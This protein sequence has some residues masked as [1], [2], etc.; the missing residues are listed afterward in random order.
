MARE[1]VNMSEDNPTII[2]RP[3]WLVIDQ[4]TASGGIRYERRAL[5]E[6]TINRGN[7]IKTVHRSTKTVDHV[8]YC[9]AVDAC[10]KR[11]DYVLRKHGT[12]VGR[13]WFADA[14]GLQAIEAEVAEIAIEADRLNTSD[15]IEARSDRRAYIGILPMPIDFDRAEAVREIARTI[16]E[17][18]GEI[19]T[20]LRAGRVED[21]HKLKLRSLNMDKLA[22]GMQSDAIR[23]ALD[24]FAT[25]RRA[26]KEAART[27]LKR[28]HEHG[29]APIKADQAAVAAAQACGAALDLEA[30]QVAIDHFQPSVFAAEP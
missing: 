29:A 10:V 14:P 21:F 24:C 30:I 13:N 16:R 1:E 5:D 17:T 11:V 25:S 8:E 26:V 15:A 23:F 3:G 9:A 7:G 20:A 2:F 6:S 27:A 12:K 18:L 19:E 28:A 4:S 22:V